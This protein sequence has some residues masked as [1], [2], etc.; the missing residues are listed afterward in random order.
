MATPSKIPLIAW[1]RSLQARLQQAYEE[2]G[3]ILTHD[4]SIGTAR[5]AIVRGVLR[6]F[7]P[8]SVQIGSGQVLDSRG[9][10]SKQV[11]VV[12]ARGTAPVFR[13]DGEISA[14]LYETV[15]ATI[16]VKSMLYRERLNEALDNCRSVKDLAFG[17]H[18]RSGG[19]SL[20]DRTFKWVTSFG[21]EELDR[22][23]LNPSADDSLD[24]PDD[25]WSVVPFVHYWLHWVNGSF[26]NR[27]AFQGIYRLTDN[28]Q[29]DFFVNLL[30]RVL[31]VN[32]SYLALS[33]G[34]TRAEEIKDDFFRRLH[35]Y[36]RDEHLHPDTFV[37]AYGGYENLN[38]LVSEVRSW[39]ERNR[40]EVAWSSLPRL[41]MNHRMVMVRH[42]NEYHC[43]E[44]EY[45]VVF[46]VNGLLNVS[47][48]D[49]S[50]RSLPNTVTGVTSYFDLGRILGI[51]HPRNSPS[52]L[53]WSIPIEGGSPGEI[54]APNQP[55]IASG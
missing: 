39:Y 30:T 43:G 46:L 34:F 44:L 48:L 31:H 3:S 49:L 21:L 45:P 40:N 29:F 10:L 23:A 50:F 11:D 53:L 16:E 37:L 14:F 51:D 47:S 33:E 7:L 54:R 6:N 41:I 13:F 19:P 52:Y 12:V 20:F 32:D 36:L 55:E 9:Q 8:G 22:I 35:R 15:L 5:E 24:C 27:D 18:V 1:A 38:R 17:I 28:A 42:F 4:A 26:A 2:S 25:I